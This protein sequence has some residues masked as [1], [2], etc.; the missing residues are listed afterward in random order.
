MLLEPPLLKHPFGEPHWSQWLM[1][2]WPDK[3]LDSFL[4]TALW[5]CGPIEIEPLRGHGQGYSGRKG[6]LVETGY[7]IISFIYL[8]ISDSK[9][10]IFPKLF[11]RF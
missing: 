4:D 8:R 5:L 11:R 2:L 10:E 9:T 1:E 3:Q 7:Q 6:S